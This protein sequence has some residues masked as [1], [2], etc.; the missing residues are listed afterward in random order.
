MRKHQKSFNELPQL[1]NILEKENK[2]TERLQT[3]QNALKFRDEHLISEY[4]E[5]L[6]KNKKVIKKIDADYVRKEAFE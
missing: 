2:E 5:E 4:E 1:I 3:E 6:A